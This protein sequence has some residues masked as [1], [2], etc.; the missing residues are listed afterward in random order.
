MEAKTWRP[1]CKSA[2]AAAYATVLVARILEESAKKKRCILFFFF[3]FVVSASIS[4]HTFAPM[5]KI[6]DEGV[7]EKNLKKK[8]IGK[9]S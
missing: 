1:L 3:F 8:K 7:G 6:E 9:D 2:A 5:K 4:F